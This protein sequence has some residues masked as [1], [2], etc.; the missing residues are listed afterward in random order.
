MLE[1]EKPIPKEFL[2]IID[3]HSLNAYPSHSRWMQTADSR[4]VTFSLAGLIKSLM[5]FSIRITV[6]LVAS[7][8]YFQNTNFKISTNLIP[9]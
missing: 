6:F 4:S 2:F 9:V 5:K 3:E 7:L 8:A 1:R